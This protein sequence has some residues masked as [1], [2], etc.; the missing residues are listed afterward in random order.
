MTNYELLRRWSHVY[1]TAEM[2][3][4]SEKMNDFLKYRLIRNLTDFAFD[5]YRVTAER[6]F[7]EP[8]DD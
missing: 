5:M 2:L 8:I 7:S 1:T 6:L 3:R 4:Q